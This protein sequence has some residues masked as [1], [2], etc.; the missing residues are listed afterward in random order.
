[1][2]LH[3]PWAHFIITLNCY[4]GFV[5]PFVYGLTLWE[6]ER[7]RLGHWK[8]SGGL[9]NLISYIIN[10]STIPIARNYIQSNFRTSF[11]VPIIWICI[12]IYLKKSIDESR[13]KQKTSLINWFFMS[14][15]FCSLQKI[16]FQFIYETD[17]SVCQFFLPSATQREK[18]IDHFDKIHMDW[19]TITMK[20]R[21]RGTHLTENVLE[22]Y[23]SWSL[24]EKRLKCLRS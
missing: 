2:S 8:R 3:R 20:K 21:K 6:T 5:L 22:H 13:E 19:K 16:S 12:Y 9:L 15:F 4:H 7:L 23:W 10:H 14:V 1:M 17:F 11:T 18:L 24:V